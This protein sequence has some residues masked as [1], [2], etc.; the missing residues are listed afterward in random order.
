[1]ATPLSLYACKMFMEL[2]PA[3]LD[4]LHDVRR[5]GDLVVVAD[6]DLT[7]QPVHPDNPSKLPRLSPLQG[8]ML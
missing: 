4:G 2:T 7:G 3:D 5:N 8:P 6:G 1:M